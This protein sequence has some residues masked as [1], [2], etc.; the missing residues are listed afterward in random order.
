M[1]KIDLTKLPE[2]WAVNLESEKNHPRIKEFKD[3]LS[4]TFDYGF[5]FGCKFYGNK[6]DDF[7]PFPSNHMGDSA[8]ELILNNVKI[9]T[10]D[11]FFKT[12]DDEKIYTSVTHST[13]PALI[14]IFE[15]KEDITVWELAQCMQFAPCGTVHIYG[16]QPENHSFMRHFKQVQ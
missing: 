10:L 1:K 5:N 3:M 13:L 8:K 12:Q 6:L 11:E 4:V 9:I 16:Q 7:Q 14:F 2:R 15:P